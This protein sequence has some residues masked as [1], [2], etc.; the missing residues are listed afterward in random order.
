MVVA[1]CD[2]HAV[3][4]ATV[5]PMLLV[6]STVLCSVTVMKMGTY[7]V[8]VCVIVCDICEAPVAGSR[9]AHSRS[10]EQPWE[11]HTISVAQ[12]QTGP[13]VLPLP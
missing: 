7:I 4:L 10:S 6:T 2:D 1:A 8:W 13:Q 11:P 5:M 9:A 3:R 12:Q